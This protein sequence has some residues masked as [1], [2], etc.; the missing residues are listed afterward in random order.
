ME[1]SQGRR[2]GQSQETIDFLSQE[3]IK[4]GRLHCIGKTCPNP[5]SLFG[6]KVTGAGTKV[7]VCQAEQEDSVCPVK[8]KKGIVVD[9]RCGFCR[10][11]P[12]PGS[13]N[14]SELYR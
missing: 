14:R 5:I 8:V 3:N 2:G 1:G 4:L 9:F 13:A 7:E 6:A 12:R 11:L 10:Y